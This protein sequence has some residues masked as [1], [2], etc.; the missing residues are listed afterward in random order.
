MTLRTHRR[1]TAFAL[2]A[3]L[4]AAPLL[5]LAAGSPKASVARTNAAKPPAVATGEAAVC[6]DDTT[7]RRR[8]AAA[9][10]ELGRRLSAEPPMAEGDRVLN[11]SGHNYGAAHRVAPEAPPAAPAP[12]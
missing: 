2:G 8:G 3:L 10:E 5:A 9:L 11:R 12:R 7:A 4:L 1:P 6:T